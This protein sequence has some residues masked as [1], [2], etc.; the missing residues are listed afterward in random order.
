VCAGEAPGVGPLLPAGRP[1]SRSRAVRGSGPGTYGTSVGH[2]GHD[3]DEELI[4]HVAAKQRRAA[5]RLMATG[6]P[7]RHPDQGS[8]G[9]GYPDARD[10]TVEYR[11]GIRD[12]RE[13]A[14]GYQEHAR[15]DYQG[16][17]AGGWTGFLGPGH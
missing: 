15:T 4:G 1:G 13:R 8:W 16:H 11:D 17:A 9:G 2:Q 7:A 14:G 3:R 6:S 10:R 5:V 12:D